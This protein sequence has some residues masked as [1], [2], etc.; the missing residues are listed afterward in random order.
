M[1]GRFDYFVVLAGMRTGSNLLE[2][3]LAAMP[4]VVSHGELFNPHFFGKPE[5]A[6]KWGLTMRTRDAD[7]VRTIGLMRENSEGFPGFRLFHDHDARA[8]DHVLAD[9]RAAKIVLSRRPIDSYVSLKIA[10]KTGQ[11]WLGDM[12]SARGARVTFEA[13]EYADFLNELAAFQR[14]IARAL[15]VSGQT[16]FHISYEDL[17]DA[18]IVAGLGVFIGSDG[19]PDPEKIRAKVQNPTPVE[20]RLTNPDAA[21]EA[22]ARIGTADIGRIASY[23]PDRGPGLRFF[24]VGK[25][26]PL[27]YM[28]I[29]GAWNDP[30]PDWLKSVDPEGELET[31]MTQKDLRRWKRQ[32]PG[33]RSFTVLRHPL[34]RAHDAFCRFVLPLDVETYAEERAA[35][36]ARYDVPLPARFP[37]EAYDLDRHRVAFLA[38]LKFLRGNLGG[39]TSVRVDSTWASQTAML[40]AIGQFVVPDRVVRE[41]SLDAILP[42]LA[43]EVGLE[44]SPVASQS[45]DTP[46]ALGEVYTDEIEKACEDAYRR[47]YVM[48][49]FRPWRDLRR[50]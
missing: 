28:P 34:P 14:R 30:V 15:Q 4:G 45:A 37:D 40:H 29:R 43:R 19:P 26:A 5:V 22:L 16:A 13:E 50:P 31:G 18:D 38:Y 21:E 48:F 46:F 44:P 33:H 9:R 12:T 24:R 11:W 35:L 20:A 10:R 6:E 17:S 25:S 23:E 2:E 49:G 27:I 8:I 3:Q 41:E 36:I 42:E 39:Q 32:H 47:D 1:S 7:P